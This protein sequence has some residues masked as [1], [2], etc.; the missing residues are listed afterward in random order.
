MRTTVSTVFMVALLQ[1][2]APARAM[3]PPGFLAM[4]HSPS[5]P[6]SGVPDPEIAVGPDHIML[7]TNEAFKLFEKDGDD[8]TPGGWGIEDFFEG[9]MGRPF[10]PEVHYDGLPNESGDRRWWTV[11][12]DFPGVD[13]KAAFLLAVTA[14]SDPESTW[15]KYRFEVPGIPSFQISETWH[16]DSPNVT[17]DGEFLY[18][19]GIVRVT[20]NESGY[21]NV[22]LI[23]SK[24]A[25][26]DAIGDPEPVVVEDGDPE[27]LY[28]YPQRPNGVCVAFSYPVADC[29]YI[30]EPEYETN[31][32]H[33]TLELRFVD[34]D[35]A[36]SLSDPVYIEVGEYWM[37]D[38]VPQASPGNM[39]F[40]VD[41]RFWSAVYRNGSIWC[42]HHVSDPGDTQRRELSA[43]C[44]AARG[45]LSVS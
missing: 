4:T 10:D 24:E 34:P 3:D 9:E 20:G 22:T 16:L 27:N 30:V 29:M 21:Y 23:F 13:E 40:T 12:A 25:L 8:V 39:L 36:G 7:V 38:D 26:A 28:S 17:V 19:N 6:Y 43:R 35:G 14:S 1:A 15:R 5:P 11:A 45:V 18:L 44:R 33:D 31:T 2:M 32:T 42:V 41:G 37:P